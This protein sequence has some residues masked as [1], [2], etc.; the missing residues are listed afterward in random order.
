M[1]FLLENSYSPNHE[2]IIVAHNGQGKLRGKRDADVWQIA[3]DGFNSYEHP[4]QKPVELSAFAIKHHSD[5]ESI[6]I[7]LFGGSGPTLIACEQLNRACYMMEIDPKYC[8]VIRK[9]Y[10][11]FIGKEKEWKNQ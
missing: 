4:T 6:V 9:R 11:K 5:E 8:D 7:D 10:Y 3:R 2:F 1:D